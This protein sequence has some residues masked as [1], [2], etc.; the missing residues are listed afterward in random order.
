MTTLLNSLINAINRLGPKIIDM[1]WNLALKMANRIADGYP[2]FVSAGLRLITGVLNGIAS[3]IGGIV[4]AAVSI[5]TNFINALSANL[6]R[7]AQAGA[8]MV[9]S[10]VDSLAGAINNNAGRMRAAG[11]NLAFAIVDG[12]TGGLLS[13]GSRVIS[14]AVNMASNALNAAKS[15]LGIHSPSREFMKVGKFAAQGFAKGLTGSR[16]EI[17]AAM[18]QMREALWDLVKDARADRKEA[19]ENLRDLAKRRAEDL[20]EAGK[21]AKKR[22]AIQKRYAKAIAAEERKL[23]DARERDAKATSAL[24]NLNK[25]LDDESRALQKLASRYD[26]VSKKLDAANQKLADAKR[27]RD[28]YNRSIRDQFS[29]MDSITEETKVSDYLTSLREQVEETNKFAILLQE[30]RRRGLNDKAYKHLLAQGADAL[31]FAEEL[32]AGGTASIDELNSLGSQLDKASSKLGKTASK[33]LYQAGVDAAQGLVDGLEK[34]QRAIDRAM[35]RIADKMVASIKKRLGIK[36]PSRKFREVGNWSVDGLVGALKDSSRTVEKASAQVGDTALSALEKSMR[37]VG[38]ALQADMDMTPTIRPVLDL[39]QIRKDSSQ[40]PGLISPTD[41]LKVDASYSRASVIA[42][43][44]RANRQAQVQTATAPVEDRVVL[45]YKQEIS[46]PK[47]TSRAE[48]YRQT[49]NLLSQ[50]KKNLPVSRG[51]T[52]K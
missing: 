16:A 45:N 41:G 18:Q 28:D 8:N 26:S 24:K 23:R 2:K 38:N 40:I 30:L 29:A 12:M 46:S 1:V 4:T 9:I 48:I 17:R 14:A 50:T 5:I 35:E 20:K 49:K 31:P 32:I 34:Q 43:D 47:A 11:Q 22:L 27:T 42:Q 6:P 13:G 33:E 37:D 39:E 15:A 52:T 36:S 10:L 19:V 3:N 25:N 7:I 51:V 21:D 44:E